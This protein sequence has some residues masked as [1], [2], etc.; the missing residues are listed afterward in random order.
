MKA[1]IVVP[2]IEIEL[3]NRRIP[4][5]GIDGLPTGEYE[6]KTVLVAKWDA[7]VGGAGFDFMYR[8]I[9]DVG[10]WIKPSVVYNS[11]TPPGTGKL[12]KAIFLDDDGQTGASYE[13][14]P[15]TNTNPQAK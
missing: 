7:V 14:L 11:R 6:Q 3:Q 15:I 2:T 5:I 10:F 13:F 12:V 8:T 4:I 9:G 1:A